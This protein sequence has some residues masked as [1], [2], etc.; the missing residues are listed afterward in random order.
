MLIKTRSPLTATCTRLGKGLTMR[1][2]RN[3]GEAVCHGLRCLFGRPKP[4]KRTP[5]DTQIFLYGISKNLNIK[6][7]IEFFS[8]PYNSHDIVNDIMPYVDE[9][10]HVCG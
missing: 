1:N 6:L 10:I 7:I 8:S 3:S 2:H 5:Q 9:F 4:L